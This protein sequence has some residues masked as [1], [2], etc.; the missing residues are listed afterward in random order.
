MYKLRKMLYIAILISIGAQ[1]Y[2]NFFVEGFIISFSIILLP[3]LLYN[4][5]NL[6]P[7]LTCIITGIASPLFRILVMSFK[8]KDFQHT[9]SIVSPDIVFYLTYGLVFYYLYTNDPNKNLTRFSIA[10]L[11]SDF[12]SNIVEI[13]VRTQINGLDGNIVKGLFIIASIRSLIVI[14]IIIILKRYKS[15]L[16]KLEHEARYRRLMLLTSSFKSEIYFMNKNMIYIEDIMK[17]SFQAYKLSATKDVPKELQGV[18]LDLTK[19]IHEIKKDYIRVIKGLEQIFE[20]KFKIEKINIKDMV[21]ILAINT[22]EYLEKENINIIVKTKAKCDLLVKDHYYL[23]SILRN[24]I[25][26]AIEACKDVADPIVGLTIEEADEIIKI[27]IYDN[28][29]GIKE[30]HMEYI[31]NP[32]FST[33]FNQE[34]GDINRGI[35]LTLVKDLVRD[36]FNGT[37]E[38]QSGFEKGTTFIITIDK[39]NLEGETS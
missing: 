4:N 34:T 2:L 24:L 9:I 38:V 6:N 14:M 37:I 22:E 13:S 15:L 27:Y 29:K 7:V 17:K 10:V 32:G 39:T 1:F 25:N 20:N 36:H 35:G 19:D 16:F 3:I 26:N 21:N 18:I 12:L 5:R 30:D 8:Y 11:F 23:M 33:K 31:F 28:G